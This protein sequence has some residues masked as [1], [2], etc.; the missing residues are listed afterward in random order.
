MTQ[1]HPHPPPPARTPIIPS[2]QFAPSSSKHTIT[3]NLHHSRRR[4]RLCVIPERTPADGYRKFSR[5]QMESTLAS[6]RRRT[7]RCTGKPCA[8]FNTSGSRS[9]KQWAESKRRTCAS[10]HDAET[11]CPGSPSSRTSIILYPPYHRSRSS[12]CDITRER[13]R[14]TPSGS[15][16]FLA[17][18]CGCRR[19]VGVCGQMVMREYTKM[20]DGTDSEYWASGRCCRGITG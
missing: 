7:A 15:A 13:T 18:R 2:P 16:R 3:N 8:F 6:C 1:A 14:T 17:K 5:C 20:L 11:L 9:R 19:D 10:E 4:D 12:R